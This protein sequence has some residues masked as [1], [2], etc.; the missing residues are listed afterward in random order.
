MRAERQPGTVAA[1]G[2][3]PSGAAG[4]GRRNHLPSRVSLA[5]GHSLLM[6]SVS[7]KGGRSGCRHPPPPPGTSVPRT[8]RGRGRSESPETLTA[9]RDQPRP[10][11][12]RGPSP[13]LPP[14][15]CLGGC[16]GR[17]PGQRPKAGHQVQYF[18]SSEGTRFTERPRV[19]AQANWLLPD[20]RTRLSC[21]AWGAKTRQTQ[22]RGHELAARAHRPGSRHLELSSGSREIPAAGPRRG[23][24]QSPGR[25]SP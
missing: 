10:P 25:P 21:R 7:N 16:F 17:L 12:S 1:A 20:L 24:D 11:G 6:A 19:R 2:A 18:L 8:G 13:D 23:C 15:F 3:S 14:P 4:P 5:V 9:P 22:A